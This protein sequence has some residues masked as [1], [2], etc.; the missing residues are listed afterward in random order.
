MSVCCVYSYLSEGVSAYGIRMPLIGLRADFSGLMTH[1]IT[2][3]VQV[4]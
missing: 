2:R 3:I 1:V 4:L